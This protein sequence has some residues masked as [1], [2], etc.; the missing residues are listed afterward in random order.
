MSDEE[1]LAVY[2]A[3]ADD[4]AALMVAEPGGALKRFAAVLPANARVLD[5]GC[6][7]GASAAYLASLGHGALAWDATPE[8]VALAA[9]HPGVKAECRGFDDLP[10]LRNLDGVWANFSLLHA[11][12]SAMPRHL[13]AIAAAL[14]PEG[15]FHLGMK[16][17]EGE[18]RDALGRLYAFYP[19]H[20]LTDLLREAGLEPAWTRTGHEKGL[21]GTIDPFILIQ[22]R[23][24]IDGL[25]I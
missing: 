25:A 6:G 14:K 18:R 5:L 24:A 4:Y 16:L 12:R 13:A 2:A 17:G 11:P 8:M 1:T 21:A 15:L 20:E 7:P 10:S 23:N 19:E 3:R 9:R 22:G